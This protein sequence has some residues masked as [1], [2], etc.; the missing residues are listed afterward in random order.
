MSEEYDGVRLAAAIDQTLLSPTVGFSAAALWCSRNA[1]LGF[2]TLCVTP[3]VVPVAVGRTRGTTTRVCS[4]AGFPLGYA[5]TDVK[6]EEARRLVNAGCREVDMV[7]HIG[8]LLEGDEAYVREDIAEVVRATSEASSGAAIV[9]VILETGH[10]TEDAIVAACRLSEAAGAAFV[11]TSTGFGPRGAS[12]HDVELMRATVGDRLGVKAAGGIRDLETAL[13]M[14]AAG[15]SR[16][17]TS[18]GAEILE[19]L[20]ARSG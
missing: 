15:A 20:A 19:Q 1:S 5:M 9:K 4:V 14:L 2:A 6:A 10:L 16:L 13:A 12:V 3:S 18:S 8:A 7:V 17:G 11:K